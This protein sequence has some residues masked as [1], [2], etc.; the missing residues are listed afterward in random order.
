MDK[1]KLR[2][3][4]IMLLML[5]AL[6]LI[7]FILKNSVFSNKTSFGTW[8]IKVVDSDT[9]VVLEQSK[10]VVIDLDKT[11]V[12][13]SSE[14]TIKLP[15]KPNSYSEKNKYPYGYTIISY[16]D[17]YLPRID[18]NVSMG[19]EADTNLVLSLEKMEHFSNQSYTEYFH[20]SPQVELV[21]LF[22]HYKIK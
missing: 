4:S 17:G 2:N 15:Q 12:I 6:F 18:H 9:G 8:Q 16:A 3:L 10:F 11:F 20:N 7:F 14:N 1:N 13:T 22:E 5:C 21:E 19:S